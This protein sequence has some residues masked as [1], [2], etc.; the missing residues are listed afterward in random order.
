VFLHHAID[1]LLITGISLDSQHLRLHAGRYYHE[2]RR[3]DSEARSNML[4]T[5]Q[6]SPNSCTKCVTYGISRLLKMTQ[7]VKC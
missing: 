5:W 4:T 2:A 7:H 1:L 3:A 6:M